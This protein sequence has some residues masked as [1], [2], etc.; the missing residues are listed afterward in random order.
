MACIA[1]TTSCHGPALLFVVFDANGGLAY[2]ELFE[3]T[4]R[5]LDIPVLWNTGAKGQRQQIILDLG[6]PIRFAT[7]Q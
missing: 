4:T 6:S 7:R 2:E 5:S 1:L 3:S